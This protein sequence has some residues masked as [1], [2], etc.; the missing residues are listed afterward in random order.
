MRFSVEI[1]PPREGPVRDLAASFI[2]AGA[3]N[4]SLTYGAGGSSRARSVESALSLALTGI[5]TAAHVTVA[6]Q[7]RDHIDGVLAMW[8]NTGIT[9]FVALRGDGTGPGEPFTPHPKGY[10]S[11]LGPISRLAELGAKSIAVTAYPNRHPHDRGGDSDLEFLKRKVDAGAT[12]AITQFFFDVEDY[13]RFRDRCRSAGIGIDIVPG[14]LPVFNVVKVSQFAQKCGEP[15]PRWLIDR[16]AGLDSDP[17]QRRKVA[18]ATAANQITRL[19]SEG[20]DHVHL[21][22]CNRTDLTLALCRLINFPDAL[23]TAA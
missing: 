21:Y 22:S 11:S 5:P 1:F 9:R 7:T 12:E 18:V 19:R 6:G 14:I 15:L 2:N 16:F 17:E 10:E 4:V 20:V 23:E 3:R 8:I 13:L